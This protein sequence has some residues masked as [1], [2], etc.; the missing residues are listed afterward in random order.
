MQRYFVTSN[1]QD[2]IT[3]S[4]DQ[5]HHILKV[6][7][8]RVG[9]TM[10]VVLSNNHSGIVEISD[11]VNDAI[12]VKWLSNEATNK[13]LPIQVTIASGLP[14]G[15]KLEW[16]VQKGTELGAASFLPLET[17]WSVVKWEAKKA[18]KKIERLQK[19]A[20]EAAEQSHR[21]A[22]PIIKPI[23]KIEGLIKSF[24]WYDHVLIAYEESAKQ[25]EHKQLKQ[26]LSTIEHGNRVLVIFGPEGGLSPKEISVL[27]QAGAKC[28]GLGPR[29]LR[30]ETAPLYVL[31]A[32]SYAL[33]LQ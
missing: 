23:E 13:E 17:E 5:V 25:Q 10:Y 3:F 4:P 15:D 30:A 31:S 20:L 7:R 32:I 22:V 1:Q 14:K 6:M 33:E 11:I 27:T 26:V 24:D 16:I 2:N 9:D 21:Q 19:I 18:V 29:I 12:Q 28:C 8:M